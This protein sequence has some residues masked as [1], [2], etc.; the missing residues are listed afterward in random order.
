VYSCF[1]RNSVNGESGENDEND[2]TGEDDKVG[3]TEFEEFDCVP[4]E[5]KSV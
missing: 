3:D 2:E 1:T 5:L 4:G